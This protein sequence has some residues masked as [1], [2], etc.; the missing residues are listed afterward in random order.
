MKNIIIIVSRLNTEALSLLSE[1][2]KKG[3]TPEVILLSEAVYMLTRRGEFSDK[4]RKAI[5]SGSTFFALSEDIS[6]RGIKKLLKNVVL[7]DYD[8]LVELLL[9][10]SKR[11]INL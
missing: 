5:E 2:A 10:K 11:T 3:C 1:L 7:I 6:K 4:I 9:E 8:D